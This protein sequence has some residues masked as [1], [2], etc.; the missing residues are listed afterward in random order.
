[1]PLTLVLADD[2]K[3]VR[4]GLRVLFQ[5]LPDHD[6]VGEAADGHAAVKLALELR[7]SVVVMD[8]AM[9]SL[10]GIEATRH[11][12]AA[13]YK[14]G[15]VMLSMHSERRV[16]NQ[17]LA[18]GVNGYVLKDFAFEQLAA[19]VKTVAGGGEYL[20]PQLEALRSRGQI[21]LITELLT[22]REREVLQMLAEGH[23]AKEIGFRLGVS[24]KTVDTHRLNL[25]AK[26]RAHSVADLI[27]V[28]I[29]EGL[30]SP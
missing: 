23:G 14:A 7:P 24:S 27:R 18:A 29:K 13:G 30:T 1:M 15:V 12:R 8:M 11:L 2:H 28:A 3:I 21:P 5:R 17:A 19:A 9:P 16:V 20:S 10:N 22:P 25:M 4:D 6:V 26:L